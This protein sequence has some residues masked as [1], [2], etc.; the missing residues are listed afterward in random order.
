MAEQWA[1]SRIS[2]LFRLVV[3]ERIC[4]NIEQK[5]ASCT[6]NHTEHKNTTFLKGI[7]KHATVKRAKK[8]QQL[9]T[10]KLITIITF[11]Y[12]NCYL[13]FQNVH[14]FN[15]NGDYNDILLACSKKKK[16][17]IMRQKFTDARH[18]SS[19][20]NIRKANYESNQEFLFCL[21][22]HFKSSGAV[23]HSA[24]AST[25]LFVQTCSALFSK[26]FKSGSSRIQRR[27]KATNKQ[28]S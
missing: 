24:A 1:A 15:Q 23:N 4:K 16:K 13:F 14:I 25:Q 9:L 20:F 21:M 19:Y 26:A 18:Q 27:S 22:S 17:K 3:W 6:V 5:G 8:P 28:T 11:Q 12:S 2:H 7:Q 10:V